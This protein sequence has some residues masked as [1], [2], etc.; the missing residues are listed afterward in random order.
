MQSAII[1]KHAK[2]DHSD[3]SD[4]QGAYSSELNQVEQT[5]EFFVE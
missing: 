4:T 2:S 3:N 1:I 5:N